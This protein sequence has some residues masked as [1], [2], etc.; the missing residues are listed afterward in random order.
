VSGCWPELMIFLE[1]HLRQK[2]RS[3]EE[4]TIRSPK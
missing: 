1:L 2:E 3:Q 4:K